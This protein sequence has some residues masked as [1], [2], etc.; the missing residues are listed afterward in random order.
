M[1]FYEASMWNGGSCMI[2]NIKSPLSCPARRAICFSNATSLAALGFLSPPGSTFTWC[3]IS[4][5]ARTKRVHNVGKRR[6]YSRQLSINHK[7]PSLAAAHI[8]FDFSFQ[9]QRPTNN[10]LNM[11][12]ICKSC[13]FNMASESHLMTDWF[14][15]CCTVLVAQPSFNTYVKDRY[16]LSWRVIGSHSTITNHRNNQSCTIGYWLLFC[17]WSWAM[18]VHWG[19]LKSSTDHIFPSTWTQ[20]EICKSSLVSQIC[21]TMLTDDLWQSHVV[22]PALWIAG[23]WLEWKSLRN[24]VGVLYTLLEAPIPI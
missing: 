22:L 13:V 14:Q 9:K 21:H 23:V 16:V 11:L 24:P 18:R 20:Y 19:S 10:C 12:K 1:S 7:C 5:G 17:D 6:P 2:G 8:D 3:W 4:S 15:R